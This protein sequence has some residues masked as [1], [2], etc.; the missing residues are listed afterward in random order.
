MNYNCTTKTES[1]HRVEIT[2]VDLIEMLKK[3]YPSIP[4]MAIVTVQVGS[5]HPPHMDLEIDRDTPIVVTWTV[6]DAT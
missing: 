4:D 6:R 3:E 2:D 5:G 1:T